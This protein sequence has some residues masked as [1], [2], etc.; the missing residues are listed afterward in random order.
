MLVVLALVDFLYEVA[1]CCVD[2]VELFGIE[3]M[4]LESLVVVWLNCGD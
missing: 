4:M 2:L 3:V 1:C